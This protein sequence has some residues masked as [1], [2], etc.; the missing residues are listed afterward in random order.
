MRRKNKSLKLVNK[1]ERSL[2]IYEKALDLFLEEGYDNTPMAKVA[3][4][5][6]ISKAGLY[7]YC[8][9]KENLLFIIHKYYLEKYFLPIL[10]SAKEIAEPRERLSF[11]LHNYAKFFASHPAPRLL[12]NEVNRLNRK[13]LK[14]IKDFWKRGFDLIRHTIRELQEKGDV[15]KFRDSFASFLAIGMAAWIY[16]WFDYSRP[17]TANELANTMVDIF[18]KGIEN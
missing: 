9:S 2:H 7:Y 18:F 6:G 8:S 3:Q 16:N 15:K 17:S 4:R 5:A 14:E 12:I 10:D 13:H 11:L 1:E